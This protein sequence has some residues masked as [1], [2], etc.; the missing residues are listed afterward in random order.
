MTFTSLISASS[1]FAS[2]RKR[3][4][5][6]PPFAA[7]ARASANRARA[8]KTPGGKA[9]LC[10]ALL[11]AAGAVLR[12]YGLGEMPPGS[13]NDEKS[14]SYDAWALLHYGID[15]NGYSWPVH[16]AA[17]GS[18]ANALYPY[19]AMPFIWIAGLDTL[20]Y[21]L[22]MAISGIAALW[23]MWKI[24]RNAAGDKLALIALALLAFSVWHIATTRLAVESYILPFIILLSAY[25]LSRHDRDRF[26]V[27]AAA[28][29]TIALS[30]YAYGTAYVFAPLFLAAA[31]GWL[32]LNRALTLRRAAALSAIAAAVA[33]PIIVFLAVNLFDLESVR[34]MGATMPRYPGAARYETA[35]LLFGGDWGR[36]FGN[37]GNMAS[38]LL[39]YG[40]RANTILPFSII[41]AAA[42]LG[43]ALHGAARRGDFGVH[44]LMALWFGAA[45]A[46]GAMTDV[47][48]PVRM[49]AAWMPAIYLTALGAA[50]IC[51]SRLALC[52]AAAVFIALSGA[53][54][55]QYFSL[56]RAA[57]A[58]EY[59]SGLESAIN[60]AAATA[61]ED[62]LIYVSE[63]IGTPYIFTLFYTATPPH[64]YLETRVVDN[65][66]SAFQRVLTFDR[67]VFLS[68][69]NQ[70]ERSRVF[71][72]RI[73]RDKEALLYEHL[74]TAGIDIGG[75]E[76]YIL[77]ASEE[78][79][80]ADMLSADGFAVERHGAFLYAYRNGAAA[81]GGG[82]AH[83]PI[84]PDAPLVHG[85]PAARAEFDLHIQDGALVYYKQ[86]CGVDDT[87]DGFFLHVIPSDISDIAEERRQHGFDNLDFNF[88]EYGAL[89]GHRCM[90]RVPLPEYGIAAIDTGQTKRARDGW[91]K[92]WARDWKR[93]W[94]AELKF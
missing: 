66:N 4:D 12:L 14:A 92:P 29:A 60:R 81:G 54:A 19:I 38:L 56:H 69:F 61:G 37:L 41:I 45:L 3:P 7:I 72:R 32:A 57:A 51:R 50:A 83:G 40:G 79:E 62:D 6:A 80:D 47:A 8:L 42:G 35:S 65:P 31:F 82:G 43:A 15:R 93:L 49:N 18:G 30:V 70:D 64:R 85:E 2:G 46:V 73:Y 75:I 36:L 39:G 53:S 68:A 28:A 23:L 67:F 44:L 1:I 89:F 33:A 21:R 84:S 11:I 52:A 87:R 26:G 16:F 24:A 88:E 86:P 59:S 22:P 90:A 20:A 17:W 5:A 34:V 76:H 27:Q 94:T 74:R 10:A 71:Q 9:A 77:T 13:V 58:T 63:H 48:N 91:R 78:A 25:L 55:Y